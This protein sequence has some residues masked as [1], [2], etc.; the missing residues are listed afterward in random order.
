[1]VIDMSF[2]APPATAA[3]KHRESRLGFEVVY[4]QPLDEG[5]QIYGCT[6]AIE[7][8]RTWVIEYD[9]TLD[10]TWTTRGAR[11]TGRS[12]SGARSLLLEAD[13]S[14]RWQVDGN[15]APHLRGCLDVDLESSAMTNALPVHRL[16]L[17]V[18]GHAAAPAVYVRAG[19]LSVERL[20]Q[21]YVRTSDENSHQRYDYSAP[22]FAFSCVLVYDESGFLLAYPGLA[23][24]AA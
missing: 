11:I 17:P 3:W 7:D 19:D 1:M 8:G 18:D 23:T 6:T 2:Q 14:G 13:G 10:A 16:N 15:D 24:R 21:Q 5:L 20:E 9:I 4:F 22:A 12:A